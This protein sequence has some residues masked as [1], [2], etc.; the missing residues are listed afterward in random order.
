MNAKQKIHQAKLA[1]WTSL[2]QDQ[3]K[4]G[5]TVKEWC[6]QSGFTI[7]AYNYWK[8]LIKEAVVDSALPDIV[9]LTSMPV[10][11]SQA[12]PAEVPLPVAAALRESPDLCNPHNLISS[13]AVSVALGDIKIEIGPN[14][15]DEVITSIIKAVRH[16]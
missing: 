9:P 12:Y 11:S 6:A 5:L 4:S 10:A 8:H 16:A 3:S 1:Q 15:S 2:I 14:A 13:N 7:H